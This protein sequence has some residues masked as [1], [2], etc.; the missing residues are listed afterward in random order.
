MNPFLP[1]CFWTTDFFF[2]PGFLIVAYMSKFQSHSLLKDALFLVWA[3]TTMG[4]RDTQRQKC[5]LQKDCILE[6]QEAHISSSSL[7]I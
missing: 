5:S 2:I 1:F 7:R 6:M 4:S 3:L